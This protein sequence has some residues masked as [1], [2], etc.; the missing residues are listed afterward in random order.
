ME[1]ETKIQPPS[2]HVFDGIL[3]SVG[4]YRSGPSAGFEHSTG[5]ACYHGNVLFLSDVLPALELDVF[6][7]AL[8]DPPHHLPNSNDK[9]PENFGGDVL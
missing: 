3:A 1:A 4:E 9:L 2:S 7:L 8:C 6:L 5:L